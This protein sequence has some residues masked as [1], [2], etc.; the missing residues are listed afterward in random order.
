M[1]EF[2]DK[3]RSSSTYLR[4]A[5]WSRK[6]VLPGFEGL[7]LYNVAGFFFKGLT[8]GYITNRSAAAAFNFILALFPGVIFLFTLIAFLP[9]NNV[10]EIL[11]YDV[12]NLLPDG[13]EGYVQTMLN[14]L[15]NYKRGSL[16][17]LGL[18]TTIYFATN[19]VNSMLSAFQMSYHHPAIL[20][21]AWWS[22]QVT[23]LWLTVVLTFL[24]LVSLA[25]I[26]F[27]D[28]LIAMFLDKVPQAGSAEG[29]LFAVSRW[30]IIVALL[31]FA[32]SILYYYALK[33]RDDWHFFSAGSSLAT[34]AIVMFTVGFSTYVD[35][36]DSYH[37][38]YG[39]IG[40]AMIL[41]LLVYFNCI[42]VLIGYE[43]N[44]SIHGAKR[45]VSSLMHE[46]LTVKKE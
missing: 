34:G 7:P 24:I 15:F 10:Y 46:R 22:Q 9:L 5:A 35:H 21:R 45:R 20:G 6:V 39:S 26:I 28:L 27:G 40:T 29:W 36:F 1:S 3:V 12:T 37:K 18:L 8:E 19:G 31:Y 14:D 43:L 13:V 33:K 23:A 11:V 41:M 44:V 17:S 25:L 38:L 4:I 32:I 2:G 30:V 16:L 42:A